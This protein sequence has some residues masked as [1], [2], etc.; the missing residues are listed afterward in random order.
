M[1][2][3]SGNN[4]LLL[5][6]M[7]LK[8]DDDHRHHHH[9][10]RHCR[11]LFSIATLFVCYTTYDL[12]LLFSMGLTI[13]IVALLSALEPNWPETCERLVPSGNVLE[14]TTAITTLNNM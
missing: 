3:C 1:C 12:V 10:H 4:M 2:T 9:H 11:A 7:K 13:R 5:F 14:I 6:I 8:I